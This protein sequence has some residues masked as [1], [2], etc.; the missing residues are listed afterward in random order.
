MDCTHW[1]TMAT[2]LPAWS[3]LACCLGSPAHADGPQNASPAA[4]QYMTVHEKNGEKLPC[5]VVATWP[6]ANGGQGYQVRNIT[7]GEFLTLIAEVQPTTNGDPNARRPMSMRLYHWGKSTT[8]PPGVPT[9]PAAPGAG[10]AT[11]GSAERVISWDASHPPPKLVQSPS[12][13]KIIM[14]EE[15]P[16]QPRRYIG[17]PSAG[18]MTACNS[19][20]CNSQ[21]CNSPV[22]SSPVG[23]T[24]VCNTCN[25]MVSNPMPSNPPMY[26]PAP[27][28]ATG[29]YPL[30]SGSSPTTT[31]P[32]RP[33]VSG[34]PNGGNG[35]A[36]ASPYAAAD[37]GFTPVEK[38]PFVQRVWQT[39]RSPFAGKQ[40]DQA[41]EYTSQ[42]PPPPPPQAP[43]F[44]PSNALQATQGTPAL[45]PRPIV[46]TQT[47]DQGPRTVSQ[48]P[49]VD[50][51]ANPPRKQDGWQAVQNTPS[52]LPGSGWSPVPQGGP[53]EPFPTVPKKSN[54]SPMDLSPPPQ[55]PFPTVARPAAPVPSYPPT[56]QSAFPTVAKAADPGPMNP[57]PALAPFPTVAKAPA[58]TMTPPPSAPFPSVAKNADPWPT[59]PH[60]AQTPFPKT[61]DP[62]PM[63]PP[64]TLAPFPTVAKTV[65]PGP[66]NSLPQ[67]PFPKV[68][69]TV[70]Q[71]QTPFPTKS[72]DPGPMVPP[73]AQAPFPT[74]AKSVDPGPMYLPPAQTPFPSAT[75]NTDPSPLYPPPAR[76][77][78]PTVT[79]SADT[80][81]TDPSLA[82]FPKNL[83]DLAGASSTSTKP[84]AST[85]DAATPGGPSPTATS[86][87]MRRPTQDKQE[88][89]IF[90][91]IMSQIG[92]TQPGKSDR[93]S[94]N[95]PFAASSKATTDKGNAALTQVNGTAAPSTQDPK[96]TGNS[97]GAYQAVT[98][99][100]T[101]PAPTPSS[102]AP[103]T[104]PAG[105]ASG[106]SFGAYQSA[107]GPAT[108]SPFSNPAQVNSYGAYQSVVV[109]PPSFPQ[110]PPAPVVPATKPSATGTSVNP[111]VA[112]STPAAPAQSSPISQTPPSNPQ[113]NGLGA[114][115]V[116]A[117]APAATPPVFLTPALTSP[118]LTSPTATTI[119]N[120]Q[121]AGY[122]AYQ[123]QAPTAPA[124]TSPTATTI[125]KPQA[126]GYGAYQ[127][128][129]PTAP[130]PTSPTATAP[131]AGQTASY[132]AYQPVAA[133]N[134]T[135]NTQWTPVQTAQG[136][137][138]SSFQTPTDTTPAQQ[139]APPRTGDKD[140]LLDAAKRFFNKDTTPTGSATAN[141]RGAAATPFPVVPGQASTPT[142][143][144]AAGVTAAAGSA[145][146]SPKTA[147]STAVPYNLP[148]TQN[149]TPPTTAA[150]PAYVVPAN[151]E[152]A[153]K[154]AQAQTVDSDYKAQWG[155]AP[156]SSPAPAEPSKKA[157]SLPFANYKGSND[158]LLN[159]GKFD[160]AEKVSPKPPESAPVSK[161]DPAQ[162][163]PT[164]MQKLLGTKKPAP[165]PSTPMP[166]DT[167]NAP[168][169][170]SMSV[171]A[172]N[173]GMP[174]RFV[175]VPTVTI[176]PTTQNQNPPPPQIPEPMQSAVYLNAFSQPPPPRNAGAENNYTR[177]QLM[178][179]AVL[180]RVYATNPYL[181]NPM[182]MQ[183][184]RQYYD[185]LPAAQQALMQ[186]AYYIQQQQMLMQ[187]QRPIL[188]VGYPANYQGPQPPNPVAGANQPN[189][190]QAYYQQPPYPQFQY[191]V[192]TQYQQ[193]PP[194]PYA[195]YYGWPQ[196]QPRW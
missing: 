163:S 84:A 187:P 172:A 61:A 97:Y 32:V 58:S 82:P 106:T 63:A 54:T 56:V 159:P 2:L 99:I 103:Q 184:D 129:A 47:N 115:Q 130:A 141:A 174:V 77:P 71:P 89:K 194:Y 75:K 51:G 45:S 161:K 46:A 118:T 8:S 74:I 18:G 73:A 109:A 128:Q 147:Y 143:S 100:P 142:G 107:G 112:S 65:D 195:P 25:P 171:I 153:A 175:P 23:N 36:P 55:T 114:Y 50:A 92:P 80:G 33:Q 157:D 156:Q 177:E 173:R 144:I 164:L 40:P 95:D 79:K 88:P 150:P 191:Q 152:P 126:A 70:D 13:D 160:P 111:F 48:N 196:N 169:P 162:D 42:P 105:N 178:N 110:M 87:F 185:Q 90:S 182:M 15:G 20:M 127:A 35:P 189:V 62:G 154:L 108:G 53:L 26:N 27:T 38:P 6:L 96:N 81:P 190:A 7:T 176:P 57:Q 122:G 183:N 119:N 131:S 117:Q 11:S 137:S 113:G 10:A 180:S 186:Q 12:T 78:F 76:T 39:V 188:P 116:V 121:A 135:P 101:T 21:G 140:N 22:C 151:S 44:T 146:L 85:M 179:P 158:P 138:A 155:K 120:P 69:K 125:N 145:A 132:G 16:N 98:Q 43:P 83:P 134:S 181:A 192:Y 5:R 168:P 4:G 104:P 170:G 165:A 24:P 66:M 64:A 139:S 91:R 94:A 41:A 52:T 17:N 31:V 1:R 93:P 68:A 9:P 19:P 60:P 14:W 3:L 37:T 30:I 123:A 29:P 149:G 193:Y 102:S 59:V 133:G 166:T 49:P 136:T 86:P 148:E 28:G 67:T 124:P 167:T 72:A 34:S